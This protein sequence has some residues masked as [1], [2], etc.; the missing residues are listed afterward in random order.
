MKKILFT[1]LSLS[2]FL[3]SCSSDFLEIPSET[4][5]STATFYKT[6]A[7]L[8]QAVNAAYAPL[9]NLYNTSFQG[10]YIMG[11]LRSDNTTYIFNPGYRGTIDP[12]AIADFTNQ[13]SNSVSTG[14]YTT[15]YQ[16]IARAN[17]LLASVEGVDFAAASKNN[18][19]GQALFLRA[20]AYFDLVQYFGKVPLHLTPVTN[21]EEAALPLSEVDAVYA[22]IIAD[23]SEAAT[24]LPPKSVQEPGRATSGAAK[25]LLGN[26]HAV[27]KDWASAETILKEVIDSGEYT[28]LTD[29]ASAFSVGNKNNSES[30][31]EV[32]Y[33]EGTEGYA[34]GFIYEMLPMPMSAAQVTSITGASGAQALTV[35]A[36]NIPT[37][38]LVA[39]YEVGD[40]R[41][42][43]SIATAT[44]ADG[45]TYPYI[46][47][48]LQPHAQAGIT[49]T[50]WPVYRYSEVLLL[51]AEALNEQGKSVS[52][53]LNDVRNRAGLINSLAV[54][55]VNLRAAILAE[56]RVE[57]AFENKR[58]PDLVR[59][60]NAATVMA[61]Y[62]ARVKAN[63][64]DY[65]FPAG[66]APA[67]AAFG[68][69]SLLFPLPAS[70]SLL[71]P[72]F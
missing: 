30:V 19:K 69:I 64:Q 60:G 33:K 56:R 22:Q 51:Y 17:Q 41:K 5:L 18:I 1:A 61:A 46:K 38:D 7:D 52:H 13:P 11:E 31:F 10:A 57:L 4:S 43:I 65:Y 47:K 29:Y 25:T 20:L 66:L 53:Y 71:S 8:Q 62:G 67:P 42:S 21:R 12:E 55:Q 45:K 9:R 28:L 68:T 23:A 14:K 59:T 3:G 39:A 27:K 54:G 2:L 40:L 34:S 44:L 26:L 50:N 16:I 32:Q 49:G 36:Y 35:E 48:L 24:L 6:E 15:N 72:N 70:E 37:P 63:P 58:W